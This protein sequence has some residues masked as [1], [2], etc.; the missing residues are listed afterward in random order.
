M[1]GYRLPDQ[2]FM[3]LSMIAYR[4]YLTFLMH[5]C[6]SETNYVTLKSFGYYRINA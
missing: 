6:G 2:A 1:L 5:F 4:Y 3:N